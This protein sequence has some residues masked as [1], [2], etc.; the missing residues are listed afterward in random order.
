LTFLRNLKEEVKKEIIMKRIAAI[1]LF[2]AAT[3][4]TAGVATAQDHSVQDTISSTTSSHVLRINNKEKP[5]SVLAM[6]M[7]EES[8][9]GQ[10][11]KLVFHRYGDQYFLSEILTANSSMNADFPISKEESKARAQTQVAGLPVN[12]LVLIALNR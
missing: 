10:T 5:A 6:A 7:S 2:I 12:D 1:A 11:S 9:P 3:F 4:V 8:N